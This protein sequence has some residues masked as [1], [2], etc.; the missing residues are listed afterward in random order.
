MI[1][2]TTPY[3]FET[4]L[5][6]HFTACVF[7]EQAWR[8]DKNDS[9]SVDLDLLKGWLNGDKKSGPDAIGPRG[10]VH[11]I[12]SEYLRNADRADL[13]AGILR[14]YE[15]ERPDIIRLVYDGSLRRIPWWP[16]QA[17]ALHTEIARRKKDEVEAEIL[18]RTSIIC[19]SQ[20]VFG[21]SPKVTCPT[22]MTGK[23]EDVT[24]IDLAATFEYV[25]RYLKECAEIYATIGRPFG[26]TV[27]DLLVRGMG[28]FPSVQPMPIQVWSSY[29]AEARKHYRWIA[30]WKAP[31]HQPDKSWKWTEAA[32]MR[33]FAIEAA[34]VA[35]SRLGAPSGIVKIS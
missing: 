33:P 20:Y 24:A 22:C 13:F 1:F 4:D 35:Q 10:G 7:V 27:A 9:T 12:S 19:I 17:E 25:P 11:M 31:V 26:A 14:T 3:A 29:L 30:W 15:N 6:D 16:G 34:G 32:A 2:H 28:K 18:A 8:R 5:P 21:V 23:V